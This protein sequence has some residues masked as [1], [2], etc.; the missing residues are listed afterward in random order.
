MSKKLQHTQRTISFN[1]G[2][3]QKEADF[4]DINGSIVGMSSKR[5]GELPEGESVDIAIWDG[6][7]AVMLPLDQAVSEITTK[8]SFVGSIIP[9]TVENPGRIKAIAT[10]SKQ[11][12]N[13]FKI[14]VIIYYAVDKTDK[15][16]PNLNDCF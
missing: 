8:N 9:L 2:D 14:K 7:T 4:S 3:F 15:N 11:V 5:I 13:S 12:S 6:A 16:S 1:Q 10:P